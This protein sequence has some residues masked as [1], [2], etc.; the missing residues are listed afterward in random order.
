MGTRQIKIL[1]VDH[2]GRQSGLRL[3]APLRYLQIRHPEKR[4]YDV[5]IPALAGV[6]AGV[7]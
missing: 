1:D 4:R 5:I 6:A 2:G 3:L 7:V